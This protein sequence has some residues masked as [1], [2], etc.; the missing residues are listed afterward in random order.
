MSDPLTRITRALLRGKQGGVTPEGIFTYH[1][2]PH[3]IVGGFNPAKAGTGEGGAAFGKGAAYLSESPAVSGQGGAYWNVFLPRF[4]PGEAEGAAATILKNHLFDREKAAVAIRRSLA[5]EYLDPTDRARL[6]PALKMLESGNVV[7]PRTYEVNFRA[8]PEELLDWDKPLSQQSEYVRHV[9]P[10]K[11]SQDISGAQIYQD[12]AREVGGDAFNLNRDAAT[13]TLLAAGIPGWRYLDRQSRGVLSAPQLEQK[14]ADRQ[15][16]LRFAQK[17]GDPKRI[18]FHEG[19]ID[20]WKRQLYEL[21]NAPPSYNYVAA[22][23]SKLDIMAK[24][25][26][27]GGAGIGALAAGA[28]DAQAAQPASFDDRFGALADPSTYEARP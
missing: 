24:Y 8:K 17:Q 11:P 19:L 25:G 6:E 2:S 28:G 23:P 26:I 1:S 21:K 27:V 22:D 4:P 5:S 13:E 9:L 10:I 3:D 18:A 7:G 14:I 12:I 16:A 15:D 20:D